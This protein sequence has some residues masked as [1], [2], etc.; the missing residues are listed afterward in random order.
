MTIQVNV[1]NETL[2]F[3]QQRAASEGCTVADLA[4]RMLQAF[5]EASERRQQLEAVLLER[6]EALDRGEREL[7][8]AADWEAH[9]RRI[10]ERQ[11]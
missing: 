10:K 1:T 9:R 11:T 4:E 5:R 6:V 2:Q 8:T 7:V 3:M